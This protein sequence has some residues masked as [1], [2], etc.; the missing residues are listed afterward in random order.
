MKKLFYV[1]LLCLV[2]SLQSFGQTPSVQITC[3]HG[4][5]GVCF[6]NLEPTLP[7]TYSRTVSDLPPNATVT[8]TQWTLTGGSGSNRG[9][10]NDNNMTTIN[11]LTTNT[12]HEI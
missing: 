5:S 2:V 3:T 1:C 12:T 9:L 11:L 6:L 7:Y 10:T 4:T 8:T